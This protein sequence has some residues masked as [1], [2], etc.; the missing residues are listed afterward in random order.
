MASENGQTGVHG[1][2]G[3]DPVLVSDAKGFLDEFDYTQKG[4]AGASPFVRSNIAL[5][6]GFRLGEFLFEPVDPVLQ[7]R[8]A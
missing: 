2:P 5:I 3:I 1:D 6:F 4:D 7:C 8:Q